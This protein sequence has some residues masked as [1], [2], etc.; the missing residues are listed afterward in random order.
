M[1]RP[2]DFAADWDSERYGG[3]VE[4]RP[5]FA[6]MRGR[7]WALA[8]RAADVTSANA[9]ANLFFTEH[10]PRRPGAVKRP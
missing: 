4:R 8:A 9:L 7:Q 1:H 2:A 5:L 6:A 10:C 3:Y